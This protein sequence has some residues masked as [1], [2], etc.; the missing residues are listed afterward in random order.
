MDRVSGL[1]LIAGSLF[2]LWLYD[3]GRWAAFESV[4]LG[5]QPGTGPLA[6]ANIPAGYT[7]VNATGGTTGTAS[8]AQ[9]AACKGMWVPGCPSIVHTGSNTVDSILSVAG[10]IASK[11]PGIGS[12]ASSVLSFL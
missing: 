11:I 7:L 12:I 3:T 9:L 6:P 2:F 10:G 4:L 1:L 8:S 5:K